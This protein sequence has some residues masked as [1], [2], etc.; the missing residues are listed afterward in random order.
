MARVRT[1]DTSP[2]RTVRTLLHKMGFRFQLHLKSLPGSPDIVLP[3]YSTVIFVHGCFWHRHARC[4]RTTTPKTRTPF[5]IAKFEA[6]IA[7]DRSARRKLVSLG[8]SVVTV[9]ECQTANPERLAKVL[10]GKLNL[11]ADSTLP[12]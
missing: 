11:R 5:W 9:W 1:R 2:E 6:N 4:K 12:R 8:W 3:K 10:R 7:R